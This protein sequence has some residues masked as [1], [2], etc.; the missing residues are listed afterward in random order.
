MNV[1]EHTYLNDIPVAHNKNSSSSGMTATT[2]ADLLTAHE[3]QL[4]ITYNHWKLV[5]SYSAAL[6]K[7]YLMTSIA[8]WHMR[9]W[10]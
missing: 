2:E 7:L 5:S 1:P 10:S 4:L 9:K 8:E 6:A 3:Q